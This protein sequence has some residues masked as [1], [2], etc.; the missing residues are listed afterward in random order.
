MT[1]SLL[2]LRAHESMTI[3]LRAVLY[4]DILPW[5]GA[6]LLVV[7][8]NIGMVALIGGTLSSTDAFNFSKASAYLYQQ[9]FPLYIL[10][11][12][13]CFLARRSRS[14]W[15]WVAAGLIII[16][17]APQ[18][19]MTFAISLF[20]NSTLPMMIAMIGILA[21]GRLVEYLNIKYNIQLKELTLTTG[22]LAAYLSVIVIA[23]FMSSASIFKI[24]TE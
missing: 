5:V 12:L 19:H 8:L 10:T 22:S 15:T 3:N 21:A 13:G 20:P 18:T 1:E 16:L 17:F 7:L 14:T 6:S 2:T 9:T 11:L 4:K 23:I 24:F